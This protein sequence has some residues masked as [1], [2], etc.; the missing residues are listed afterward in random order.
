MFLMLLCVCLSVSLQKHYIMCIY[1]SLCFSPSLSFSLSLSLAA[2]S[3]YFRPSIQFEDIR[4]RLVRDSF[5]SRSRM[6]VTV[7]HRWNLEK[8]ES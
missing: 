1:V 7:T 6:L 3:E 2:E 8:L 4:V 5:S